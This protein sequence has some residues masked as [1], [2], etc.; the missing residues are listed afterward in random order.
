MGAA[1]REARDRIGEARAELGSEVDALVVATRTAVDIPAKVRR[2]PVRTAALAGGAAFFAI[3]GPQRLLRGVA[4][5]VRPA[6]SRPRSVLPDEASR[7][8]ATYGAEGQEL[9]GAVERDF[10]DYL[11]AG[12]KER[13]RG[14][15]RS[16]GR[17]F[18]TLFDTVSGPVAQRAAKEL[19][20]R[21][22]APEGAQPGTPDGKPPA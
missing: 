11:E 20:G 4:R 10:A 15:P 14:R 13:K 18:W 21:L 1:T 2:N 3:K 9:R 8:L 19:A 17:S 6:P 5:R 22:F 16:A 7:I 12:V